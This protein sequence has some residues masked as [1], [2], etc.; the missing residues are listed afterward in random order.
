MDLEWTTVDS[1]GTTYNHKGAYY[2]CDGGYHAWYELVAPYKNQLEG[3]QLSKW[4]SNMESVRK[5]VECTYGILKKRFLY[6]KNP[7]V[8]HYPEMI[9][10]AFTT[11][12]ALHNWLHEEDG[13]D[14]REEK[15]LLLAEDILVE[16]NVL[17]QNNRCY[18]KKSKYHGFDG[19]FTRMQFRRTN[20]RAF[21]RDENDNDC[22]ASQCELFEK[23]RTF[24]INHYLTMVH[25]HTLNVNI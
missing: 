22:I 2:V 10:S 15:G 9:E 4:S 3:S 25:N 14:N 16:Y 13:W 5:D 7:I 20:N 23:R 11:A 12:C 1:D 21:Y 19:N 17:D 18:G 8:H 6:L 24:L